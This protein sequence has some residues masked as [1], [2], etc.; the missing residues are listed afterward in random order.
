MGTDSM[1]DV[2]V[3]GS[4]ATGGWAAKMLTERGLDVVVVEAGAPV[5]R[6]TEIPSPNYFLRKPGEQPTDERFLER[7]RI[8]SRHANYHIESHSLFV[9]DIDNPYSSSGEFDWIRSRRVGGRSLVWGCQCWQ[10]SDQE[11]AGVHVDGRRHAWPLNTSDLRSHYGEIEEYFEICGDPDDRVPQIPFFSRLRHPEAALTPAELKLRD[12]IRETWPERAVVRARAIPTR[13]SSREFPGSGYWPRFSSP[14]STLV[15]AAATGRLKLFSNKIVTRINSVSSTGNV[16]IEYL[17]TVSETR[18]SLAARAIVSCA[19]TV[20]SVR[21]LL[22]SSSE[23]HPGGIGNHSDLLGRG[24]MDHCAVEMSATL[25]ATWERPHPIPVHWNADGLYMPHFPRLGH[26]ATFEGGYGI[27]IAAQ[28]ANALEAES[29]RGM[30]AYVW[31]FGEVLPYRDNRITLRTDRL[32]RWGLATPHIELTYRANEEALLTDAAAT[33]A[34]I[35]AAAGCMADPPARWTPGL[36][37]HE[38]GGAAMGTHPENS[39]TDPWCRVWS[40]PRVVV[41]DGACWPTSAYQNPTLTM[42]AICRRAS[43]KLADDLGA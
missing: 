4:G 29:Q 19:S 17:D 6:A 28:R 20:E 12:I 38:I 8:Q 24:L 32:D 2:V 33:L 25:P 13:T 15:D 41:A 3:V 7:Q 10:L 31:A 23:T 14:G 30:R 1:C 40:A 26:A 5:D 37:S 36:S 9:D 27:G 35:F 34:A 18:G 39:V 22:A 21:L 43:M 11:L 42:M 16:E